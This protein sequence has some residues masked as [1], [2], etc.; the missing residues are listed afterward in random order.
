M[1]SIEPYKK[2]TK[3][4]ILD[5]Y[6][7]QNNLHVVKHTCYRDTEA[8]LP[9]LKRTLGVE[10]TFHSIHDLAFIGKVPTSQSFLHVWE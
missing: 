4:T 5:V 6:I 3:H 10:Q 2:Y 7:F 9:H 1:I 8:P